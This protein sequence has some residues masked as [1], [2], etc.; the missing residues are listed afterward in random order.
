M[1]NEAAAQKKLSKVNHKKN[2]DVPVMFF[3]TL[4]IAWIGQQD[5][6]SFK[7]GIRQGLLFKAKHKSFARAC[8]QVGE[9]LGC[10]LL[11]GLDH[12]RPGRPSCFVH[13]LSCC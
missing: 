7:E 9:G 3:G 12:S 13:L 8:T 5:I 2:H 10:E 4:E 11:P 1:L 6:V